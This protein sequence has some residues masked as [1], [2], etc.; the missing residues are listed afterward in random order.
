MCKDLGSQQKSPRQFNSLFS[1]GNPWYMWNRNLLPVVGIYL[2]CTHEET[3]PVLAAERSSA[4]PPNQG[5]KIRNRS[6]LLRAVVADSSR[7]RPLLRLRWFLACAFC[8]SDVASDLQY[9]GYKNI[10]L[11]RNMGVRTKR[12]ISFNSIHTLRKF[13]TKEPKPCYFIE[14]I[15]S[16][17]QLMSC[18][19]GRHKRLALHFSWTSSFLAKCKSQSVSREESVPRT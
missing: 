16:M 5:F 7:L 2:Y 19:L 10:P 8:F 15:T 9:P 17:S 6:Q 14:P 4:S 11:R 1:C 13:K 12:E 18:Y 3:P